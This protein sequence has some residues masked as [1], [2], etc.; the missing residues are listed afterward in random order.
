M[1]SEIA[2]AAD[3]SKGRTVIYKLCFWNVVKAYKGKATA[4]F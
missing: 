4:Y 2:V 1:K 3:I